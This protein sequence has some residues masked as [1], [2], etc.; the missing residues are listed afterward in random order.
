VHLFCFVL[1]LCLSPVARD[2]EPPISA[3]AWEA[4][5]ETDL[6]RLAVPSGWLVETR[7]GTETAAG[8]LLFVPD[9]EYAWRRAPNP[10]WERLTIE[11]GDLER[12]RVPRGWIVRTANRDV[13]AQLAFVPDRR[14]TW[15]P[16][17]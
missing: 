3:A 1:L 8:S 14:V 6:M 11:R 12:I 15:Q 17:N 10:S 4:V 9:P 7:P 16:R 2:G 5:G 13:P